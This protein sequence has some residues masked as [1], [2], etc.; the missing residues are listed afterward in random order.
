M[1][2]YNDVSTSGYELKPTASTSN[3]MHVQYVYKLGE[4]RVKKF[5][6]YAHLNKDPSL[7]RLDFNN[8][9]HIRNCVVYSKMDTNFARAVTNP[10]PATSGL[11]SSLLDGDLAL[12]ILGLQISKCARFAPTPF[13]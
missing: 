1:H 6:L 7:W 12:S 11:A 4:T 10:L 2:N 5:S 9:R 13:P 8:N 3:I